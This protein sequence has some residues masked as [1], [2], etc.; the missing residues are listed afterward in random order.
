MTGKG[1]GRRAIQA[2][3]ACLP[4]FLPMEP[5][6]ILAV[7]CVIPIA[8]SVAAVR[9]LKPVET[10]SVAACSA[11]MAA[12]VVGYQLAFAIEA[13]GSFGMG[14]GGGNDWRR[15][16]AIAAFLT[17]VAAAVLH[18]NTDDAFKTVVSQTQISCGATS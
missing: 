1:S 8:R 12:L 17:I 16:S 13:M 15:V 6:I 11:A 9:I 5:T 7:V 2:S 3:A 4:L 18:A 10:H 14:F